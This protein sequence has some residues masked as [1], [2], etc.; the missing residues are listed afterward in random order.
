MVSTLKFQVE[1]VFGQKISGRGA[2]EL[3]SEDI[4]LKTNAMVSYN[5]IRRL[6]G[7]VARFW[8]G[9]CYSGKRTHWHEPAPGG[10]ALVWR[11]RFSVC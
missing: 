3:L 9:L 5:T 6:F 1:K 11:A 2:A 8:C 4:Y 7:L 10:V